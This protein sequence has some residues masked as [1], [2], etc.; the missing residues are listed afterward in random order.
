MDEDEVVLWFEHDVFDQLDLLWL[1]DA[2]AASGVRRD[3]IALIVIGEHP[4]VKGSTDWG[5]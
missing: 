2:L 1:L 3:S 5:S 4:D